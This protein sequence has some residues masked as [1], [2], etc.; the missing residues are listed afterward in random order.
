MGVHNIAYIDLGKR[1]IKRIA[2]F[3]GKRT[4]DDGAASGSAWPSRGWGCRA[5]WHDLVA[6]FGL[7]LSSLVTTLLY[8]IATLSRRG[9]HKLFNN[10][11]MP[12]SFIVS[13]FLCRPRTA[14][15]MRGIIVIKTW[16]RS[17]V[18]E[19]ETGEIT[20]WASTIQPRSLCSSVFQYI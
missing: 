13:Y 16:L 10:M 8:L 2:S 20:L 11:N 14:Y 5:Y 19:K 12:W 18:G 1:P 3:Q 17:S 4:S 7:S 6:N 9:Q 15:D